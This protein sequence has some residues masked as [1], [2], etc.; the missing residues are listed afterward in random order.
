MTLKRYKKQ[1]R[2]N[3]SLLY[4]SIYEKNLDSVAI[5]LLMYIFVLIDT[6]AYLVDN[7]L[8]KSENTT[9][10]SFKNFLQN[11]D[12]WGCSPTESE[13]IYNARC[14]VLHTSR[15]R[16]YKNPMAKTTLFKIS[17][18]SKSYSDLW[19][20]Y[21]NSKKYR[22]AYNANIFHIDVCVANT[23]KSLDYLEKIIKSSNCS[24]LKEKL[25]LLIDVQPNGFL[26]S[27]KNR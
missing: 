24:K 27:S 15:N 16:S 7:N 11:K 13:E 26:K 23:F 25:G 22:A 14:G 4:Q 1:I 3:I 18:P 12:C 2:C 6:M 20:N 10:E 8:S 5:V 19:R 21:E 17:I 9:A